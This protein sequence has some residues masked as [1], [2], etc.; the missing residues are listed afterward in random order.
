MLFSPL[1]ITLIN[2]LTGEV[3]ASISSNLLITS[4]NSLPNLILTGSASSF[5]EIYVQ[6]VSSSQFSIAKFVENVG[7]SSSLKLQWQ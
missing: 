3:R 4:T 2:A 1:S 6:S 5:G 7:N